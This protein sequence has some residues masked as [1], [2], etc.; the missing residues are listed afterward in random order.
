[1]KRK[2]FLRALSLVSGSLLLRPGWA[3]GHSLAGRRT[4]APFG[5]EAGAEEVH[6]VIL[7]TN[8]TH[9]RIDPFPMDGGPHQGLGGVARRA[10]LV[11]RV[12]EAHPNVLLLDSG[13]T[14]QGTPYFNF[15]RG[16]IELRAMSGMAYDASTL[17]NHD[18]DNGVSGLVEVLPH[19]SYPFVSANY[20]VEDPG[21]A[22]RVEPWIVRDV[23]GVKV[24]IFGLGIDFEGLVMEQLHQGVRHTDP[25][26]AARRA[27]G[28]LRSQGCSLVICL[29]HLGYRYQGDRPSD[30]LL[31][32]EVDG[33]DLV[34]GGHTHTFLDRPDVY[35]RADGGQTLVNQVGFAGIRLGRI[36]VV[37][38][39]GGT[40]PAPRSPT[41][42]RPLRWTGAGYAVDSTLD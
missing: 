33:I 35:P 6:L 32:R 9:S 34:L 3:L 39:P 12:R 20:Q 14:F 15:F 30:T 7:H 13:D 23:G 17:G 28:A 8:D 27:V 37:L 18:F 42:F 31:A 1:M 25:L 22:A 2:E 41:P 16:E 24:G 4:G 5:R 10:T 38:G 40:G 29:S 36:D 26:A 19:A 21:L 11:R